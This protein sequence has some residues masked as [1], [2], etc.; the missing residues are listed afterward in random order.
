[1]TNGMQPLTP[2]AHTQGAIKLRSSQEARPPMAGAAQGLLETVRGMR[3]QHGED[4]VRPGCRD[5][6]DKLQ[7]RICGAEVEGHLWALLGRSMGSPQS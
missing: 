4:R 1:M 3:T 7:A 5:G 2:T 6:E